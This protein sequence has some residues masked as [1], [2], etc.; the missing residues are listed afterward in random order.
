MTLP[1][2]SSGRLKR[3]LLFGAISVAFILGFAGTTTGAVQLLSDFNGDG[4]DDLVIAMPGYDVGNVESA[5]A[6]I[7]VPGGPDEWNQPV[8]LRFGIAVL[9][10][11]PAYR[12][13]TSDEA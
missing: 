8:H 2:Q 6:F 13:V 9:R 10:A 11:C 12:R 5:G 1:P 7:I 3:G 4:F